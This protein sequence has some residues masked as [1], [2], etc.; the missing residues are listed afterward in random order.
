MVLFLSF[1]DSELILG[2]TGKGKN[3]IKFKKNRNIIFN[4]YNTDIAI[5]ML[6]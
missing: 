6:L 1:L 2:H 3:K 5:N 4:N